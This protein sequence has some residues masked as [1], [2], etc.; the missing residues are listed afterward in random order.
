M[1]ISYSYTIYLVFFAFPPFFDEL[2][3]LFFSSFA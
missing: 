2:L 1:P 3:N